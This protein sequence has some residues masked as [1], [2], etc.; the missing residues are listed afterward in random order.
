MS[1][2]DMND[3]TFLPLINLLLLA[4]QYDVAKLVNELSS[5][6]YPAERFPIDLII[7]AKI[8]DQAELSPNDSFIATEALN[9]LSIEFPDIYYSERELIADC[10]SKL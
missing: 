2:A 3:K 8:C 1:I 9:R 6:A 7:A 5:R 4:G 10:Q